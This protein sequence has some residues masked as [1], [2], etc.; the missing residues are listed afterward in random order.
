MKKNV[1]RKAAAALLAAVMLT[2]ACGSQS[3]GDA[4][5]TAAAAEESETEKAGKTAKSSSGKLLPEFD[6]SG[7]IEETTLYDQDGVTITA[8]SL[9][10]TDNEAVLMLDLSNGTDKDLTFISG[11]TGY[12]L[13]SINGYM[14]AD[15]YINVDVTPGSHAQE[16]MQFD[17]QT[18]Q[19]YGINAIADMKVAFE[20]EDPDYNS[21]YTG[22]VDLPTSLSGQVDTSGDPYQDTIVSDALK[23]STQME[24][25]SFNNEEQVQAENLTVLSEAMVLNRDEQTGVL[26]EVR[27]DGTEDRVIVVDGITA[28]GLKICGTNW[29][30]S[31]I[32]PGCTALIDI[33][34]DDVLSEAGR[35]QIGLNDFGS[36]EF[37]LTVL[38]DDYDTELATAQVQIENPDA[39][40]SY[41]DEGAELYNEGGI[42]VR[43]AGGP[44]ADEDD[45][46]YD[47]LYFIV[48]ND[49][50]SDVTVSDPYED[51]FSLNS[52]M[53]D[54]V[55]YSVQLRNGETG[56]VDL[57]IDTDDL[58]TSGLSDLSSITSADMRFL[59]DF[60]DTEQ[61]ISVHADY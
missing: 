43:A 59:L 55:M 25:L 10:Y 48:Q 1:W 13:N 28:N 50:G 42:I 2:A 44:F 7:T 12:C 3:S 29:T 45:S 21:I 33:V 27:N 6:T 14:V 8:K 53:T 51:V 36:L 24:L 9:T 4:D 38:S 31:V 40:A 15:G 46:L 47:H 26:L 16:A 23:N 20:M 60:D 52:V 61:E 19:I 57:E 49:S 5:Q 37:H 54:Y 32:T 58:E 18:L 35:E 56:L 34:M 39:E 30:S 41:K 17:L 22:A 11:S